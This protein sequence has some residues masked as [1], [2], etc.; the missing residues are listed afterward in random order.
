MPF[1]AFGCPPLLLTNMTQSELGEVSAVYEQWPKAPFF[2]GSRAMDQS[3]DWKLIIATS[4]FE[5]FW[6]PVSSNM[7]GNGRIHYLVRWF[8]YIKTSMKLV[9]FQGRSSSCSFWRITW[10]PDGCWRQDP[11]SRETPGTWDPAWLGDGTWWNLRSVWSFDIMPIGLGN[12]WW[13]WW[14]LI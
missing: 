8:S 1:G 5:L 11:F 7:A 14:F 13:I 9:D 6:A 12:I 2:Y 3:Q 10:C 4:Y